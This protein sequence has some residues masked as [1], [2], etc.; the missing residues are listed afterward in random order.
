MSRAP[1]EESEEQRLEREAR[2]KAEADEAARNQF[3]P[4]PP[5][6]TQQNFLQYMQMME[7]RQ[8]ITMEQQNKF[9]HDLLQQN[10]VERPENQGVT[11][12]DFQNTKPIYFA[13]APEPMDAEDWLMDTER[14]LNTVGC[15][16]LEKVRYATHLLCG[17]TAS[18]WDNIVAVYPA[19]KVFTWDEFKRKFRESN[20][21]ESIVEL[22][23]REFESLEQKDKAILTYVG[24]FR[25]VSELVDAA[26]TLE[27][28]FKQL[29]EEKRK[30]A[31]FEPKR[32]GSNKPNMSLSFKPRFNNNYNS[33]RNQAFQTA[34]Q[35]ICRSCGLPGH[36]SR[37]CR[38]PKIICFG[39]RQEGHML[40]DCPKRKN[41]GGQ[42]GG[43]G[44]QGG[45][46]GGNWKNKKPFG[47]LN[48]TSLEEVVNSDPSSDR[49]ASDTHSSWQNLF[50]LPMKDIDVILG[51][52]WLEENGAL[53]D[54]THKTVSLK[55][56]GGDRIIYQGDKHTQIEVEL[57]LNSMK[58]VKL[59]DI[60]I[61]NEFQDVFPKEL[62]RMPPDRE[63]EF[64]ID[65]IPGTAPIAKAPYK[66]GPKE[67]KELKEQLDDLEQKG[68]IQESISPWGSPVIFVDKRDGGRRMCGDY[69]NLNNV[70]IKNK[71]PLPRIQ[72]LFDQ[73]R[74]AGVFSKIDLRSGYHQIK[75]KKED[76]PKTA[77]VS[78]KCLKTPD[79][80]VSHDELELQP[81]LTYIEK[82]AKILEENW[83]QLRNHNKVLQD[84]MEASP[85]EGSHL[86]KEEDPRKTYPELFVLQPQ[87]RTKFSLRGKGCNVPDDGGRK[88]SERSHVGPDPRR[89]GPG[90]GCAVVQG[91]TSPPPFFAYSFV[92]KP[93]PRRE[94]SR[95]VTAASAGRRT[96][97]RKELSAGRNPPGVNS[98]PEGEIDAIAIVIERDIIS[99]IIIIISTIYTAI[100]TAAP[101]HRCSNS[102]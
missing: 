2:Q 13:Y 55:S 44:S 16:D 89:R 81:D 53:I 84:T 94:T 18:W 50:I 22:K 40:K 37:D 83:K 93:K 33:R 95:R 91:P 10:K 5:P 68:F 99:I 25:I 92:R 4:P 70:T 52:N 78:R 59:E 86:E 73:V 67:L 90:L 101:R 80:P 36:H 77:F 74:G 98:L 11:L 69:R 72:D 34:N 24:S 26:I 64:T 75:I 31:K 76:V 88:G 7:E 63:I 19:D 38:K 46:T 82:P 17:P 29:Q 97:E 79:E 21:P 87:L 23:R 54:C 32:F 42:S 49:Y 96:P 102:G 35:I 51:M 1:S 66:M 28:D 48:C 57:K 47:K 65:L 12:S 58:E 8:R 71:Y 45:N 3:P 100:T 20:V 30:K 43:G 6:M 39:C 60:P 41:D 27:D 85:R 14:K 15:N 56:P 62:P 9:F 61:V